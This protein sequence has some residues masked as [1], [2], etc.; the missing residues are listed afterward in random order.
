MLNSYFLNIFKK[1]KNIFVIESETEIIP[2][3]KEDII[4]LKHLLPVVVIGF[5]QAVG[6]E[7]GLYLRLFCRLIDKAIYE[8]N[9]ARRLILEE[10]ED[11]NRLKNRF[12][13]INHLENCLNAISRV[14]KTFDLLTNGVYNKESRTREKKEQKILEFISKES[15]VTVSINKI[16]KIRNRIEHI[17]ED[18]YTN[19]FI[20]NLFL[21]TD[22]DY[23]K[24]CIN[25][26]CIDLFDLANMIQEYRKIALEIFSN[27]PNRA[28]GDK[29]YYD[30]I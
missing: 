18:I 15:I 30:K 9:I 1:L 23:K 12:L 8:Y 14:A 26:N 5:D 17:D 21:D 3:I 22:K 24:I 19:K 2:K 7:G 16:S 28:V 25:N 13:I 6:R 4:L 29:F 11:N 10:I 27:L 20:S